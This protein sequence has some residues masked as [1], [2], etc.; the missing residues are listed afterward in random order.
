[1]MTES[2]V[3]PLRV[4]PPSLPAG[5]PS[6]EAE[7]LLA[8]HRLKILDTPPSEPFDRITALA[9]QALRVPILLL[10]FVDASR[11]WFKSAVGLDTK[12]TSRDVSFCSHVV[13]GRR[14]LVVMD[15]TQD[16]RFA[17]NPLVTAA[18]HIR[19][20]LGI[21]IFTLDQQPIGTLCAIDVQPR[22]FRG[23]EV[24]TLT[25]F[26]KIV[27]E[28]LHAKEF[29]AQ[30]VDVLEMVTDRERRFRDTFGS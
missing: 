9:A 23:Q 14:P 25:N 1:M 22:A 28:T 5:I 18:P 8:L 13:F 19:A 4:R 7:R 11:Q 26:A 29:V 6:D 24:E 30:T 10:S 27:E 2:S 3:P 17:D 16:I 20:Y 12:E 21:P 15:A